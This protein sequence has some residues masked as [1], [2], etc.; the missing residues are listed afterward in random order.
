MEKSMQDDRGVTLVELI[1]AVA[2]T[3]VVG[4]AILGFLVF[5]LNQYKNNTQEIDLQSQAQ[6]VENQL[7]N[8]VLNT[9]TAL[10]Q[11]TQTSE[12]WLVGNEESENQAI[13]IH[14]EES[15]RK[16]FYQAFWCDKK[17]TQYE[18]GRNSAFS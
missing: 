4:S 9:T 15:E 5:G 16:I 1:V 13:W 12:I 8:L 11:S 7:E 14:Y 18:R 3:A 17:A 6:T 10:G 2:I